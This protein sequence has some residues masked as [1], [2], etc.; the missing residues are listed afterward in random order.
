MSAYAGSTVPVSVHVTNLSR[1]PLS[2]GSSPFGLS[3][4]VFTA[5]QRLLRFD[6]P[7]EWFNEPLMP[8]ASRTID[9]AV[10]VPEAPGNYDIEFD[11]VWEGVMW[12]KDRGNPTARVELAAMAS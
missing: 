3:Y 2:R 10:Q 6:H 4:H 9:V 1:M 11:I 12:M 8:G 5:D 7:R